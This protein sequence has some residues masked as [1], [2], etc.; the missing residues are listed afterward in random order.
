M[1]NYLVT[2]S[3]AWGLFSLKICQLERA[4]SLI[5]LRVADKLV[6]ILTVI[7]L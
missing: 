6:G 5:K 3:V 4:L 2:I 1:S 7:S